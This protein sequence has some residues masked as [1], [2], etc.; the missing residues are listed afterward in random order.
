MKTT[1]LFCTTCPQ[2]CALTVT[3]DE[4]GQVLQVSGNRCPRGDA[5]GRQEIT[6]PQRVLTTTVCI[7]NTS[8]DKLLPVRS[9]RPFAR[10]LH[11]EAMNILRHTTVTAPVKM[12][13]VIVKNILDTGVDI[14]ACCSQSAAHKGKLPLQCVVTDMD[15]S[16]IGH[17]QKISDR[18]IACV[19]KLREMGIKF[20]VVTGR[21]PCM[22]KGISKILGTNTPYICNNG[23]TVYDFSTNQ[24][25]YDTLIPND[26]AVAFW[27]WCKAHN[28]MCYV[29]TS[30]HAYVDPHYTEPDFP[31]QLMHRIAA[32]DP[33]IVFDHLT[34]NFTPRGK[35][36]IKLLVPNM[37]PEASAQLQRD[38]DPEHLLEISYSDN[39]FA[40]VTYVGANKG[41]ALQRLAKQ[42]NFDLEHTLAMGDNLNDLK[43]LQ[44][45]GWPIATDNAIGKIK[46]ESCF[47]TTN[48]CDSPLSHALHSLFPDEF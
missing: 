7:Q 15:G 34:P 42:Y 17:D 10:S 8:S 2:E 19:H 44:L 4:S 9:N 38:I 33:T 30:Q 31:D 20:F 23:G 11:F 39:D 45:V 12:G 24:N 13:D 43:M 28:Y 3:C 35:N 21:H 16:L 47:V 18:D 5:F 41:L 37:L 14:I 46:R 36:V 27:D 29:F 25:L 1:Q 32:G 40:D 6:C 26:L 22:C 48:C